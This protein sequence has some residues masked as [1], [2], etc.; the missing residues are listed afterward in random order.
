MALFLQRLA[1]TLLPPA[2][3]PH[4]PPARQTRPECIVLAPEPGVMPSALPPVRIFL[5]TERGQFRAERVF[6]WSV[7]RH[8]DPGRRYEIHLLRDLAGFRRGYWLTGFTN[9][10][11]AIPEFCDFEGRAIYND[12]DQI[13]LCDPALMF[14][15]DMGEAGFLSINDRDTSVMLLDCARMASVWSGPEVRQARRRTVEEAARRARLWGPL[16]PGWNARDSEYDPERSHLVHFTTLH[17]Q[18]WRPFP[19]Q[20]VYQDNPTGTLWPDLEAEC[21]AAGYLPFT[22]QAPSRQWSDCVE[23]LRRHAEGATLLPLLGAEAAPTTLGRLRVEHCL[24]RIPDQDL[25]WV[26]ERL[27]AATNDLQLR[28]REPNLARH[29]RARRNGWFWQQQ[30]ELAAAR[31][32]GTR[33]DF[34]RRRGRERQWLSG[35]PA[36]PGPVVVLTHRKPGHNNN[37]RALAEALARRS[38]RELLELPVPWSTVDYLVARMRGGGDLPG[39]PANTRL[40][41][42]AGWLPSRVARAAARGM[43]RDLRLVLLGRKAGSPPDHG[44]LLVQCHHF[45]MPSHPRRIRALLPMNAG[46]TTAASDSRPWQAWLDAPRRV[47]LLVGGD[48]HAHRLTD[49]DQLARRVSVWARE[50][51]ARLLV[52]SS[53]RSKPALASLAAGL[54][55]DDLLYRWQPDDAT[56]PYG[57]A[58]TKAHAL[59]VTGESESMLAD[60]VST[61]APVQIW[62]LEAVKAQPWQH[63]VRWVTRLASTHPYNDRGSIRPQQGLRYLAARLLEHGWVLPPRN[64]EAMHAALIEQ[65]LA[66]PF[67]APLDG[68]GRRSAF[69]EMPPVVERIVTTLGLEEPADSLRRH[70]EAFVPTPYLPPFESARDLHPEAAARSNFDPRPLNRTGP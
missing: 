8:R 55:E 30:L 65:G 39:L 19:D 50:Q 14:D 10:R 22:A 60:A 31:H 67:G 11:F 29:D 35:G 52:V 38:G 53:R 15:L 1:R 26:L 9:Y 27:F 58:L 61:G 42:A 4:R 2:M 17:T 6:I 18:P 34:Y 57:L 12:T 43:G 24:D 16:D 56:N 49:A 69:A 13:Y 45:D 44:G 32:P 25:P 28:V 37:A 70:N 20:Y 66:Q 59:V 36:R 54:G 33:W 64:L 62:P 63:C 47:A 23:L 48:T 68:N 5:G 40:I 41:V 3:D 21:N 7:L 51:G 46:Y